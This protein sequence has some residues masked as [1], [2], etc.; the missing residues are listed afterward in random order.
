VSSRT[1]RATQR[2]PVS[3][4]QK[5]K[6][7]NQ[8][9]KK[10]KNPWKPKYVCGRCPNLNEK[11]KND[12]VGVYVFEYFFPVDAFGEVRKCSLTEGNM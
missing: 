4:N 11:K 1:A 12:P 5:P 9:K 7:K 8:K 10:K 2:D 3:K 6:T